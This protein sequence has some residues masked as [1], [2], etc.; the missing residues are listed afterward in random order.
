MA[1]DTDA[2]R[3]L[4]Q[5][6]AHWLERAELGGRTDRLAF[7]DWLKQDPKHVRALLEMYAMREDARRA[8][9]GSRLTERIRYARKVINFPRASDPA[10]ALLLSGNGT[11]AGRRRLTAFAAAIAVF[12]LVPL[13]TLF[14]DGAHY[15][16]ASGERLTVQLR[17]GSQVRL[18]FGT[19]IRVR[20]NPHERGIELIQGEALFDVA[21]DVTRPFR[22][23]T[24]TSIVQALGT[25]FDVRRRCDGL[26][27][28]VTSGR[29]AFS[30]G[31][32]EKQTGIP[33]AVS[34]G[35]ALLV[36]TGLE[37]PAAEVRALTAQEELQILDWSEGR[38]VLIGT[39][40][41]E[42]VER[43]NR[44]NKT[45]LVIDDEEVGRFPLGGAF[46]LSRPEDFATVLRKFGIGARTDTSGNG[47]LHLYRLRPA[48][49]HESESTPLIR[50]VP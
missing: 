17:D 6:A 37:P 14:G 40:V 10:R 30:V 22:V 46:R 21:H 19:K 50:G 16:T 36:R 48:A 41:R 28:L 38:I 45:Q 29:V 32:L 9:R 43:F 35:Q 33:L 3:R 7:I 27:I 4:T 34:A 25:Q 26:E 49:A 20:F 12:A 11:G 39:P 2:E 47:A 44:F 18:N 5:S 42:A 1:Q 8:V 15:E 23:R 31:S 24:G 13:L